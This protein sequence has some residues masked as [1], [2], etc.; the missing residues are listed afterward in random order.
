MDKDRAYR[1]V[2]ELAFACQ[3]EGSSLPGLCEANSDIS[4]LLDR[5]ALARAFDL[6]RLLRNVDAVYRR[7]GLTRHRAPQ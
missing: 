4:Q 2:Q 7:V 5:R 3:A 1:L 6:K